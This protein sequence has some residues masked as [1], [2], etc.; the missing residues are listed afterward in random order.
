VIDHGS[1][2]L[3]RADDAPTNGAGQTF[4]VCRRPSWAPP[5]VP[6]SKELTVTAPPPPARLASSSPASSGAVSCKPISVRPKGT[7]LRH[8]CRRGRFRR[9]DAVSENEDGNA[10]DILWRAQTQARWRRRFSVAVVAAAV[11]ADDAP[12]PSSPNIRPQGCLA[13]PRAT[14]PVRGITSR[15]ASAHAVILT[16]RGRTGPVRRRPARASPSS[17]STGPTVA[18]LPAPARL[19]TSTPRLLYPVTSG[20]HRMRP[21]LA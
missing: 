12:P 11:A 5:P 4:Q 7:A 21:A 19:A 18:A 13:L 15:W 17:S 6:V 1:T 14:T 20:G 2:K 16:T 8:A 9:P 10:G 3:G